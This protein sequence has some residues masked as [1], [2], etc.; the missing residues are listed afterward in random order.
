VNRYF[1]LV[2]CVVVPLVAFG[3]FFVAHVADAGPLDLNVVQVQTDENGAQTYSLSL[4]V[5]LIMAGL[6]L[7]P[8][9][10]L[11]CTAF[12]RI[13]V[14]LSLLRQALGTAQTPPNQVLVGLALFITFVIMQPVLTAINQDAIAPY[15]AETI[16][17]NEAVE[18]GKSI[19]KKF[20]VA[21][22]R[23]KDITVMSSLQNIGD[24]ETIDSVPISVVIPAFVTSEL[25]TA[26]EIGFLLFIPFLVIDLVVS[27][28]LMSLGMMMLSP[29]LVSL[30]FK[31]LLFVAVDGWVMT[32][33]SLVSSYNAGT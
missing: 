31:L 6:T 21:N 22:T 33:G 1:R 2:L 23:E 24:F 15:I 17:G 28:V 18:K 11:S 19:L 27:S 26:F 12:T 14:V 13:I 32:V 20:M 10:L 29:M 30:P 3:L 4:Q 5:L 25:R 9:A 8:A 7:L 16:T